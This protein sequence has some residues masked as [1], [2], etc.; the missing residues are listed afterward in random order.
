MDVPEPVVLVVKVPSATVAE[1]NVNVRVSSTDAVTVI[2]PAVDAAT[3]PLSTA[4][5]QSSLEYVFNLAKKVLLVAL[6]L[7]TLPNTTVWLPDGAAELPV[8]LIRSEPAVAVLT[9]Q[10]DASPRLV[11]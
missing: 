2:C 6:G 5:V 3:V 11:G 8:F 1:V 7:T 10:P 9:D 4:P